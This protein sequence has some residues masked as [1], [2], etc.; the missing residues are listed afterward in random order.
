MQ[1]YL[2]ILRRGRSD[3]THKFTSS[4]LPQRV[5]SELFEIGY[6]WLTTYQ[7]FLQY[8]SWKHQVLKMFFTTTISKHQRLYSMFFYLKQKQ[9]G[10]GRSLLLASL[11]LMM[12]HQVTI[13][14]L[15]F[16]A[17][18]RFLVYCTGEHLW[19][20]PPK[21]S[22]HQLE[23]RNIALSVKGW[24]SLFCI[25]SRPIS[26]FKE[27]EFPEG[28]VSCMNGNRLFMRFVHD[29]WDLAGYESL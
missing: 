29:F 14:H 13:G 21:I 19:K 16:V 1:K 10:R 24:K 15:Y 9:K 4:P 12:F 25:P 23:V 2:R 6:T 11:V 26:G 8:F 3:W 18:A 27:E 22:A 20:S 7:H 5:H 17:W 28:F